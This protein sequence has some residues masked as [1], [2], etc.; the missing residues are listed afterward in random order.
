MN[1]FLANDF[2]HKAGDQ[3]HHPQKTGVAST[4][5]YEV[6]SEDNESRLQHRYMVQDLYAY[7]IQSYPTKKKQSCT[8]DD[9]QFAIVRAA[10][11]ETRNHS[12][13]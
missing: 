9:E 3:F 11:S 10:T 2:H 13:R 12:R 5:D 7:R 1:S 6:L 4:A 8:R